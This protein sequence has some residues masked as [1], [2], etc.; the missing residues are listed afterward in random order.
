MLCD[1]FARKINGAPAAAAYVAGA[2]ALVRSYWPHLTAEQVR[3]RLIGTATP[4]VGFAGHRE[5]D[6]YSAVTSTD[7]KPPVEAAPR[8]AAWPVVPPRPGVPD[9]TRI[10]AIVTSCAAVL[11]AAGFIAVHGMRVRRRRLDRQPQAGP[12]V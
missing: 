8:A 10:A 3:D 9:G 1:P 5:L 6:V 7:A 12:A 2:A 4:L 11:T